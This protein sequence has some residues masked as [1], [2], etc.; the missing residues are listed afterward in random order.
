MTNLIGY[1]DDLLL[2]VMCIVLGFK[3]FKLE[4]QI[5]NIWHEMRW[6]K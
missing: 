5:D 3:V 6:Y 2:L 1:V 4:H